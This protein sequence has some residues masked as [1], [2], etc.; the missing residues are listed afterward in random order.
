MMNHRMKKHSQSDCKKR[1]KKAIEFFSLPNFKINGV[2]RQE[3]NLIEH[4]F[5]ILLNFCMNKFKK[6]IDSNKNHTENREKIR[7]LLYQCVETSIFLVTFIFMDFIAPIKALCN[8]IM[9]KEHMHFK[10]YLDGSQELFVVHIV[11]RDRICDI[12][13]IAVQGASYT[14]GLLY[15]G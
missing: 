14:A 11:E 1:P 12:C 5:C 6:K 2:F 9:S 4:F 13:D 7:V 15:C 3:K 10:M 8:E